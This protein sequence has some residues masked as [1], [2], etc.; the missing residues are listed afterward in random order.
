M[1]S[2]TARP[3]RRPDN[4]RQTR[5][6]KTRKYTK[7]TAHVEARRDGKPL[8]FGWGGHL[9]R[10][11]KTKLQRRIIWGI[12]TAITV[13]IIAVFVG[14]WVNINVITP[15]LP[16][17][18]VN[19]HA[20]PQSDFRKL[21]AL[22]AQIELNKI[23]GKSGLM[24]QRDH[25]RQQTADQQKIIDDA[26]KQI[27]SLNTQL[28]ALPA[29]ATA[30]HANLT[31]ELN[32]QQQRLAQAQ[33]LHDQ[34][35]AL[36]Q[37][38]I[39]NAIPNEQQLYTQP[40]QAND[41]ANWLQDNELIREWLATQSSTINA[42]VEPTPA[43]VDRAVKDFAAKIPS[44]SSYSQF[45]SSN[46]VSDA[47]V[48]AMMALILRRSNMQTYQASLIKSP[49][50]QV[51]VRAMTLSTTKIADNL[52]KQL[53]QGGDF[54]KL[55]KA[56][57]VDTNSKDKGGTLGWLARGQYAQNDAANVSGS[58]DNWIFDPHRKLNEISPVLSEN[59]TY[60]IV[61]I[62]GVDP[63][64][65]IDDTTLKALQNN[66]LTAWL[67][68]RKATPGVSVSSIDQTKL[69]DSTNMPPGLPASAPAQQVPGTTPTP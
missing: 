38:I 54:G 46:N 62:L 17:T 52:L 3:P 60:H 33:S 16:I 42:A 67:L 26:N 36:Y 44:S 65:A 68:S 45:L 19:G 55:A 50:Y 53:K 59:G 35:N 47:D 6:T 12:T 69:L 29:S 15:G 34:A 41:S 27:A 13:F 40:Q 4:Q 14:Y 57:S 64:R 24:V 28:K 2:P 25:Y 56:N 7:Q 39:T 23:S 37:E 10:N 22:K 61:Q 21:L 58:I 5:S 48:H 9:S 31:V 51:L 43:A 1:N 66:A 20:I 32:S 63:S 49:A 18:S 8:I 30:Q 11:E